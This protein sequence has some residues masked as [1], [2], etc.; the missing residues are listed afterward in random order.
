MSCSFRNNPFPVYCLYGGNTPR[1]LARCLHLGLLLPA[2]TRPAARQRAANDGAWI[3]PRAGPGRR[4][5]SSRSPASGSGSGT[6][7][8]SHATI[9]SSSPSDRSGGTSPGTR[10]IT[11]LFAA[12]AARQSVCVTQYRLSNSSFAAPSA[13]TAVRHPSVSFAAIRAGTA[14][15]CVPC[16][17]AST[18]SVTSTCR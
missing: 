6:G 16:S 4:R 17:H 14:H 13:S 10:P 12:T 2:I 18:A 3:R 5:F 9:R 7:P 15:A 11:P 8:A 1:A